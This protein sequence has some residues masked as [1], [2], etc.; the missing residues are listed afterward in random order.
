M[1]RAGGFAQAS[2]GNQVITRLIDTFVWSPA[3]QL[4]TNFTAYDT[5]FNSDAAQMIKFDFRT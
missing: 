1:V 5:V 4:Q 2:I 3:Y